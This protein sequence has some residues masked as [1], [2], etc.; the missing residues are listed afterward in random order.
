MTEKEMQKMEEKIERSFKQGFVLACHQH[1]M[2][3]KEI[4]A[5]PEVGVSV[6]TVRAWIKKFTEEK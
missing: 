5:C 3:P 4:A 2:A 6:S 1:G